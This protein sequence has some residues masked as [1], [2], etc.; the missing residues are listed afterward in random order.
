MT[1]GSF[2]VD[3][4]AKLN[5]INVG[6][7][8]STHG[9]DVPVT[10]LDD[11]GS[12]LCVINSSVLERINDAERLGS[13]K[14]RGIVGQLVECDLVRIYVR[15]MDD[16]YTNKSKVPVMCAVTDAANEQ[17]ILPHDLVVSMQNTC[18]MVA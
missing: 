15:L 11:S 13:V 17:M 3:D 16:T 18:N 9:Q 10:C 12:E 2:E 1:K 8:S 7:S 4:V 6:I 14:I 5:Y